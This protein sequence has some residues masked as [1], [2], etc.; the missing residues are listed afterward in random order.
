MDMY[1][2]INLE[3]PCAEEHRNRNGLCL[4]RLYMVPP[5]Q[6]GINLFNSLI[7]AKKKNN[8]VQRKYLGAFSR[9]YEPLDFDVAMTMRKLMK[10]QLLLW[11]ISICKLKN[12]CNHRLL[13]VKGR[14]CVKEWDQLNPNRRL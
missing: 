13:L 9:H 1:I 7:Q 11:P 10:E 3:I 5:P 2:R 8:Y 6:K 12:N 4:V 14:D